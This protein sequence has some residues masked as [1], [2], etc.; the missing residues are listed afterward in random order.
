MSGKVVKLLVSVG[1]TVK[2]GQS[3]IVMEAMKMEHTIKAT[4]SGT[5]ESIRYPLAQCSL[6]KFFCSRLF[7]GV[8]PT[9]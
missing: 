3:L 4:V 8:V 5:V 1:D 9:T 2:I 7:P 6:T